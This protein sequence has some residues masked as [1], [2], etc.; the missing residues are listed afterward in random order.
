MAIKSSAA[1]EI[2]KKNPNAILIRPLAVRKFRPG[3]VA[4]LL[5]LF[6]LILKIRPQ[7]A[8][9]FGGYLNLIA[10]LTLFFT[11]AKIYFYEP[12]LMPGKGTFLL[13]N[14]AE[15]IFCAFA[16]TKKFFPKKSQTCPIPVRVAK[17]DKTETLY[18][19]NLDFSR[20]VILVM[21][22]SQG[23][24][25]ING[26]ICRSIEKLNPFQIIHITG[27]SG[28]S[29]ISGKYRAHKNKHIVL[30]FSNAMSDLYSASTLVVSR[31]GA[32]TLAEIAFFKLP[33]VLIP[34]PFAGGH[35][36]L[37]ALYFQKREAAVVLKEEEANPDTLLD[38]I[39]EILYKNFWKYKENLAKIDISDDG[40]KLIK[41]VV[42]K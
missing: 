23:A 21:G 41:K 35:Q 24:K 27:K 25:F 26:L 8:V 20:P 36:K 2:L 15:K 39:E 11:R 31:A 17:K 14:F 16:P 4:D 22:G 34:Y 6:F 19:L 32:G 10:V 13:K 29:E 38:A 3:A 9:C 18:R 30:P 33:A 1:D 5:K 12:N 40:K 28:F 37:N 42:L 7:K